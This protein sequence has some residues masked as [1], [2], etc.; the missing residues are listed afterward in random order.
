MII[1]PVRIVL[2]AGIAGL[3]LAA[4]GTG[5]RNVCEYLVADG[6]CRALTVVAQEGGDALGWV[7]PAGNLRLVRAETDVLAH[8]QSV[9]IAPDGS[10]AAIVS[11]GEGHPVLS[12]YRLADLLAEA[13]RPGKR[14][15]AETSVDPYPL[16]IEEVRWLDSETIEFR[17]AIDFTR[18]DRELRRVGYDQA[19]TDLPVRTWRWHIHDDVFSSAP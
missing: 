16:A 10:R 5:Y 12:V 18:V 4:C 17:S 2:F 13:D 19:T 8:I 1:S 15:P 9:A 14:L 11:V 7:D 3:S 6:P